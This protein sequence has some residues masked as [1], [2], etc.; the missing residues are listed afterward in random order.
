MIVVIGGGPAGSYAAYLLAKQGKDVTL[1]EEH[2]EIGSPVQCTGI[3]THSIENFVKLPNEVVAKRLTKVK[4]VSNKEDLVTNVDEIVMWRNKFDQ[5]IGNM[6]EKEGVKILLNHRFTGLNGDWVVVKDKKQDKTK[7]IKAE[8]VIGAD[9]PAS[10]VAKAAKIPHQNKFYIGIQA[11][12]KHTMDQSTFETHF[13]SSYPDFFG[14]VVPESEDTVRL[15][16]GAKKD[17]QPLFYKFLERVTGKKEIACWESGIIPIHNP[18]QIIQKGSV[19][20]IGDAATHVK[21]TTGGGIIP[22]FK[23]A[24]CLSD[25]IVN[26]KN[27]QKSF[28]RAKP[29]VELFVHLK[30]RNILNKFTDDDYDKLVRVMGGEKVKKIVKKYDRDTPLPLLFNL[31]L[32]EPRL[33]S[34]AK[35]LWRSPQEES[36]AKAF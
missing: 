22:S 25:C 27:Y 35:M 3:V 13:G 7:E 2:A 32:R 34:F 29:G 1:I 33:Y 4:V 15:G 6:A 26:K 14:W 28:K 23:A 12:V 17:A 36:Q 18:K 20:L 5:F 21:A 24:H 31:A 16:L 8:A 10:S 30:L 9:G 19:Y 11:K